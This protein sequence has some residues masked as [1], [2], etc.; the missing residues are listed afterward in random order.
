MTEGASLQRIKERYPWPEHRP[1][2]AAVP[3]TMDYGGRRLITDLL[4][5]R[6]LT[7]VLEVG[8]FLGGSA[9]QWLAAD[10]RVVV[11]CIDPWS[12]MVKQS[13]LMERHPCGRAHRS[14]LREP[15]GVY[16]TFLASMWDVRDRVI[17]VRGRAADKLPELHALGL[18][19]DLVYI[20]ADKKCAEIA[21]CDEL[22]P[23]ALIGGDDWNWSDGHGFPSRG[24]VRASARA[25]GRVLKSYGNT[26]LLDCRPW[27][28][29]ERILQ[30]RAL[31]RSVCQTCQALA[32]R[33]LGQ[34]S[35]GA[36]AA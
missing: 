34:T 7:I 24:P 16:A 10:P 13:P 22:F 1:S 35:T 29:G 19:P 20:D 21:V 26:W 28:F 5:N 33:L 12:D 4:A 32:R 14:Q 6:G 2:V 25:R 18:R 36:R 30:L 3:W 9:R 17:P 11:V 31:P 15:E 23:D 27:T 8:S